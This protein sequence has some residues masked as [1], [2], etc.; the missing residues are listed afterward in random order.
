MLHPWLEAR[1]AQGNTEPATHNAIG[2]IYITLNRDPV[3][4]LNNNQFYEPKVLGSFCEKLDPHLAFIAYKHA[5]GEC[6]DDLIRV[7]QENGLYKDLARYLVE[8]QDLDLWSRVLKPEGY[9]E[10][11]EEPPSRRYLLDQVVQTALPETRNGDEVSTTVKA[12]MQNDLPGELIEILERM[13]LQGSEFSNNRN[14][15]NLLLLTAIRASREK[16]M[17]YINRLDNF[18]GTDIAKMAASDQHCL[19]EEALTIYVKFAK[20]ATGE[21]QVALQVSAVEILVDKIRDLDRAKEF[22]ERVNAKAV[23]SKLAKAQLDADQVSEAIQSYIKAKDPSDYIQVISAAEQAENYEVLVPYLKMARKD[24]KEATLDTQLIYSLARINRLSELEEFVSVP[25][26][27]KIDVTGERCFDEGLFEA[28][29]ILFASINNNSKLALCYVKL[30]M[31]REAVDAAT[32][33]NS[34][35]TWKEVNLACLKAQEF[36]L[37]NICGLHIIV[38]PDHLPE[39]ISHYEHAGR[40]G[41]LMQLLEQGLGLDNAHTGIFTELGILYSKYNPEKL[42]EHI[43]IFWS[44]MNVV[45]LLRAC[46]K[47]LLW[48]ETVY[49][50]KED[51]QHDA[52]VRTMIDHPTGFIHDLFLDC[53]QKVRNPEIQYKAVGYYATQHPLQLGRLLQVLT[54]NLDHA[55]VIHQLRKLDALPLAME[56]MKS[57]QKENLSAV[58]EAL[59]EMYIAEEDFESLR[60]SV[61]DFDNFDQLYLAQRVEKHELLEFRR[62]AAYLYKKNKRWAASVHLSKEDSM[63]KDAIDTAAESA[64]IDIAEDLLRFF[65]SIHDRACFAATLYTCYDLIRPDVALELAWRHGFM[66]YSMPFL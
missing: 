2:K 53:V 31:Y 43:K 22:A 7:C 27:A 12:F 65:V 8:R 63:F 38:H 29:K 60:S 24:I 25:N 48:H 41:E 18:D 10:G 26:V 9:Q 33:A 15:Q 42:M 56:Y 55:R 11:D 64:D 57:V 47:A 37:A 34:V 62:I 16:V 52:A 32:K 44:R 49:L 51:G 36:R 39:L 50:Y 4:F 45:K 61:D 13:I 35:P 21:E 54:P 58:N 3:Q 20:K 23:W 30:S 66:D 19:Y 5:N 6:D 40:F 28:A 46:E 14:L 1:I 17:E 59:N